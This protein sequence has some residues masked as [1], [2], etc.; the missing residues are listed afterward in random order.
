MVSQGSTGGA[1]RGTLG[2]VPRIPRSQ[3]EDGIY[4]VTARG[5]G[6]KALFACD[7][8]RLDFLRIFQT[9]AARHGWICHASCLLGTHY[10]LVLEA[11]LQRLS[12]GMRALNGTYAL[13]FNRRH[14][15]RGHLFES[16]YSAWRVHDDRHLAAT[17]TYVLEN[18]VRAGLCERA[19]EWAWS[20]APAAE[21]P[22][23][24][25]A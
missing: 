6:G 24:R 15:R 16:R 20:C 13:R 5:T 11:P 8:D 3:L 22:D 10:H 23:A 17:I 18:P 4:H 19:E 7:L 2:G 12:E 1:G 21:A 14:A 25:A 9:V